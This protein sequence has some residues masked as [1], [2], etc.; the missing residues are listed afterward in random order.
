MT[1]I[2][3]LHNI[4]PGLLP[5]ALRILTDGGVALTEAARA[6]AFLIGHWRARKPRVA[7]AMIRAHLRRR[8]PSTA[9]S[10]Y[11]EYASR[12]RHRAPPRSWTLL[13][14][15]AG[16]LRQA[17]SLERGRP[18]S[19]L[20]TSLQRAVAHLLSLQGERGDWEGEM[21]WCPM[22]TRPVRDRPAR[23]RTAPG[24]GRAGRHHPPLR[25]HAH[26]RGRLGPSS[27]VAGLRVRHRARLRRA[28]AARRRPRG[29]SG[30]GGPAMAPRTAGRRPGH[31]DLG[32]VLAGAPRPL[33][34]RAASTRARPS[35]S[36]L[37]ALAA[38]P[39]ASLLLPHALHLPRR[40]P[41]STGGASAPTLGPIT[42][43]LRHELYGQPL[44]RAS[45]SP[46]IAT[47]SR[48][49]I[50]SSGRA[51]RLR[52]A[53]PRSMLHERHRARGA[54]P[55]RPRPRASRASSTSSGRAATRGCPR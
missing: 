39:P 28:P 17:P 52:A 47:P 32:Q 11:R 22:I 6:G 20:T 36:C 19:S 42:D 7:R 1:T 18:G 9:R 21:V 14:A 46:R 29:A 50:C 34:L 4:A 27:R 37:P 12:G 26:R 24:C 16:F 45:T 44:R 30:G 8:R 54:A 13:I 40:W 41:T 2:K 23:R 15:L 25:G 10:T 48:R 43:E 55:A 31:P 35:C 5:P 53:S 33:R 38:R 3:V 49:P 51:P